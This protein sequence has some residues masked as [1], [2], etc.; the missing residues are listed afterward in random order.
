M[1]DICAPRS[2]NAGCL[3]TNPRCL[4]SR[5]HRQ[6]IFV[7]PRAQTREICAP[8][9]TNTSS[10]LSC[11]TECLPARCVRAKSP[12]WCSCPPILSQFSRGKCK[13]T[14]GLLSLTLLLPFFLFF[15]WGDSCSFSCNFHVFH[16]LPPT[17]MS[18]TNSVWLR[19]IALILCCRGCSV[20]VQVAAAPARYW[21][22]FEIEG[23]ALLSAR[24]L[25]CEQ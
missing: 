11:A 5:E 24:R 8:G 25:G 16:H 4:C 9:S 21:K 14:F 6:T 19:L 7:L 3:C 22:I 23:H 17:L 2:T 18:A 13:S 1:S 12:T 20:V 15:L 10:S